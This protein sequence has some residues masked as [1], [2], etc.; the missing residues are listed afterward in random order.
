MNEL[1]DRL[2]DMPV[3]Q[4]VLML[5][6]AVF[7]VFFAYA[8]FIYWPRV[9][10]IAEKRMDLEMKIEDLNKKKALASNLGKAKQELEELLSHAI[11]QVS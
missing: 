10:V 5:V 3:R 1:V 7:L 4:R 6:G 11:F 2:M 8:Y 9:D